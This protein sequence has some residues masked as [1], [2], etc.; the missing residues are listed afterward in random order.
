MRQEHAEE[1]ILEKQKRVE[2]EQQK[3]DAC[4]DV[5]GMQQVG[6][7][8]EAPVDTLTAQDVLRQKAPVQEEVTVEQETPAQQEEVVA[9][10]ETTSA[11]VEQE[12][13][14]VMTTDASSLGNLKKHWEDLYKAERQEK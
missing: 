1:E 13:E 14:A 9:E 5:A 7:R 6:E 3:V 12:E 11:P 4:V 2:E 10:N 8:V